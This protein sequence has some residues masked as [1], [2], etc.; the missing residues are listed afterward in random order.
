[1]T[2]QRQKENRQQNNSCLHN[3]RPVNLIPQTNSA[4]FLG[5]RSCI[6]PQHEFHRGF[7]PGCQSWI[8]SCYRLSIPLI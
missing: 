7:G 6:W 3:Y 2:D 8:R 4:F 1:V 5:N